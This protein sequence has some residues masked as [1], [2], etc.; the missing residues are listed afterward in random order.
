MAVEAAEEEDDIM[1]TFTLDLS[2]VDFFFCA[3]DLVDDASDLVFWM[4]GSSSSSSESSSTS[5]S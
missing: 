2:A 3:T 1:A 5:E 4:I